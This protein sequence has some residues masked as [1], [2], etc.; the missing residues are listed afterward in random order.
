MSPYLLPQT[1]T[2]GFLDEPDNQNFVL[3]NLLLLLF[4]L[5]V[6]PEEIKYYVLID[7]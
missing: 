4:K 6:T 3:L 1:A 2:F 7:Y 5:N